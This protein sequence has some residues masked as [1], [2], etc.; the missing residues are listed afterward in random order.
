MWRILDLYLRSS[1]HVSLSVTAFTLLS[2]LQ[3]DLAVD[4]FLL[5]YTFFASVVAYNFIKYAAVWKKGDIFRP[6]SIKAITALCFIGLLISMFFVPFKVIQLSTSLAFLIYAYTFPVSKYI[7]KLRQVPLLKLVVIAFVWSIVSLLFPVFSTDKTFLLDFLFF[8]VVE[9]MVW[10]FALM[11]PFEIRDL[12]D[13]EKNGSSMVSILGVSTAKY[14]SIGLLLLFFGLHWFVISPIAISDLLIYI[15]LLLAILF[16]RR[17]QAPYYSSLW[18]E[19]LPIF[20]VLS[21]AF[22]G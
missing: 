1:L 11:I 14:L 21:W 2:F 7:K 15:S 6:T 10:V 17:K 8:A 9:R 19:S 16:T 18:V 13:D 4:I 3:F 12:P 5:I 22:V 20:W